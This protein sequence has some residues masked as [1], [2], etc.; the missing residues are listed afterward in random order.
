MCPVVAILL[1]PPTSHLINTTLPHKRRSSSKTLLCC[2]CVPVCPARPC[3]SFETDSAGCCNPLLV[4]PGGEGE[5]ERLCFACA[6]YVSSFNAAAAAVVHPI[7]FAV[8]VVDVERSKT[9]AQQTTCLFFLF[10][11]SFGRLVVLV[12]QI[13]WC[14][15][16]SF[17]LLL[18]LLLF[19]RL[20]AK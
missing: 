6:V 18:L 16:L 2:F 12:A 3:K 15:L 20:E 9:G 8:V 1:P 17:L 10:S 7:S 19:S 14:L 13:T 5:R 11:R 4:P